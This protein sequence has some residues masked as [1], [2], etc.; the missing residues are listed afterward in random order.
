M[1]FAL[2][3]SDPQPSIF[4]VQLFPINGSNPNLYFNHYVTLHV[5]LYE[6]G[7]ASQH[8]LVSK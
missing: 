4:V 8:E 2:V 1:Y 7:Y 6:T 5:Q 3:A